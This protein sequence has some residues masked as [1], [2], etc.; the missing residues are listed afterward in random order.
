MTNKEI[1]S[2]LANKSAITHQYQQCIAGH[3]TLSM[4]QTQAQI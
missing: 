4:W 3:K 2:I 1:S